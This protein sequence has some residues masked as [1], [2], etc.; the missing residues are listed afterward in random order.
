MRGVRVFLI[1]F[2]LSLALLPAA[3]SAGGKTHHNDRDRHHPGPTYTDRDKP[4]PFQSFFDNENREE[5][6]RRQAEKREALARWLHEVHCRTLKRHWPA[7]FERM[8]AVEDPGET[9]NPPSE[10]TDPPDTDP[11]AD[12]PPPDPPPPP[13]PTGMA[14]FAT[15]GA[16]AFTRS[17]N[18]GAERGLSSGP[19]DTNPAQDDFVWSDGSFAIELERLTGGMTMFT[20]G[21]SV[22]IKTI[23]ATCGTWDTLQIAILDGP[24]GA[25]AELR[26]VTLDGAM[27]PDLVDNGDGVAESEFWTFSGLDLNG[28]FALSANLVISGWAAQTVTPA[29]V[30]ITLGCGA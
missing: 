30:E 5:R 26:N 28:A 12:P 24:P 3:A 25:T 20:V 2:A 1:L 15:V 23:A 4:S 29:S 9:N 11:P 6:E 22:Q 18:L 7:K 27:L 17:T 13:S 19:G 10:P 21:N 16:V 8:C 14:N